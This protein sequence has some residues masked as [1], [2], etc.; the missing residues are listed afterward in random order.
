M[1]GRCGPAIRAYS[2]RDFSGCVSWPVVPVGFPEGPTPPSSSRSPEPTGAAAKPATEPSRLKDSEARALPPPPADGTKTDRDTR[3]LL[4]LAHAGDARVAF[5]GLRRR[6]GIHQEILTRTL[7]R[8]GR[9]GLVDRGESGY[10]LTEAGF[11]HLRGLT[12]PQPDVLALTAIQTIL[13]PAVS[14]EQASARLEGRWFR[15]LRW[16]GKAESPGE[17]TLTWLV[18]G[19]DGRLSNAI[20]VRIAGSA[21]VVDVEI[22]KEAGPERA[23]GTLRP[24]LGAIAELYQPSE[25]RLTPLDLRS[26]TEEPAAPSA[27]PEP[28]AHP[29]SARLG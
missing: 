4:E 25:P 29:T 21:L 3:I 6:L 19:S 2:C 20:R 23:F 8:L 13:P 9:D 14:A 15:G 1:P 5:A 27:R 11:A 18:E 22:G 28:G 12:L 10:R 24:L 16:Y 7:R 17:I 26:L